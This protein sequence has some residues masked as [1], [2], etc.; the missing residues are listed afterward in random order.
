MKQRWDKIILSELSAA[1]DALDDAQVEAL[2]DELL[3]P[4]RRVLC[5]GVG[6][7]LISMKAWVKRLRHMNIDLNFV[8]A[9]SEE[10]IGEG[11]LLIVASASG[12]SLFP[13][14]IAR[15]AKQLGATVLYLGCTPTSSADEL[16]DLRVI[17]RG[18]TKFTPA[19]DPVSIQPMSTLFEQQLYLLCDMITLEIMARLGWDEKTVKD[20]HA[21]LE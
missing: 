15:K 14:A 21:N 11:D 10:P 13:V 8:G 16:A 18:R 5:V 4:G 1:F 2:I 6:R 19:S 7:V 3:K 20:R 9:E 12:E 17:L